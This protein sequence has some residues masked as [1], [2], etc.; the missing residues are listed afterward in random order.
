MYPPGWLSVRLPTE[1]RRAENSGRD[2]AG[3]RIAGRTIAES[4]RLVVPSNASL[5]DACNQPCIR[6]QNRGP[7]SKLLR[8]REKFGFVLQ[9]S[10]RGA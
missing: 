3:D 9:K 2:Q 8:H 5:P 4:P 7:E 10:S 6:L 1:Y